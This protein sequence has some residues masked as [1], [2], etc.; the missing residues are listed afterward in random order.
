MKKAEEDKK[1]KIR[2]QQL[3]EELNKAKE[4]RHLKLQQD[5]ERRKQEKFIEE[6]R[7]KENEEKQRRDK[8]EKVKILKEWG[9]RKEEES[10][11]QKEEEENKKNLDAEE[12]KRFEESKKRNQER[13][14]QIIK[15]KAQKN[16]ETK[17]DEE[18]RL[19]VSE[20]NKEKKKLLGLKQ[21]KEKG[22]FQ[23]KKKDITVIINT[24]GIR[25]L[26]SS[27]NPQ[28]DCVFTFYL[29]QS[30][31][32]MPTDASLTWAVFDKLC[33]QMGVYPIVSQELNLSIFNQLTKKKAAKSLSFEEFK[34]SLI[35]IS[36][37]GALGADGDTAKAFEQL[38]KKIELDSPLKKL[39]A[40]LKGLPDITKSKAEEK[41]NKPITINQEKVKEPAQKLE[42]KAIKEP[43]A[44]NFE[45]LE[46]IGGNAKE[47]DSSQFSEAFE[48]GL[49]KDIN[50]GMSS[51]FGD[52]D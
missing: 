26:L 50:S 29:S 3:L 32:E 2:Q 34:N 37:K 23:E 40:K 7:K 45:S 42:I 8:E 9:Q 43:A 14:E 24:P 1:R 36:S 6:Q 25:D 15:E 49:I 51:I 47:A 13:L 11:K 41:K 33:Y 16:K 12:A 52:D 18:K 21:L 44:M 31:K 5:E 20:K 27:Y 46:E 19:K 17:T 10:K 39:Q 4:I 22:E 30:G 48:A 28:I 38:I 35:L